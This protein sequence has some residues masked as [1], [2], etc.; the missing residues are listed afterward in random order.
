MSW[1]RSIGA[2]VFIAVMAL[3]GAVC[4]A[5]GFLHWQSSDPVKFICYLIAAAVASSLKVSLPGIEGTLSVNF[6]FTLLGI[7][8]LSLPETLVI[9]LAS[10]LA[11]F[12]WKP[13][14]RVKVVQLV[15]NLS[16]VTVS[17]AVAYGAYKLVVIYVLHAPG[18]LALL[19][20]AIT[21]FGCNTAATST[22]IG[23]TED[24]PIASV[25][26]ES[27]LWL[28]PY[29]MVG[30][31]VAG[32]VHFLNGHIG[33][34]S[35]LLILPPIYLMYRSY[36]LYL[37]KMETEKLHAEQVSNLHLRTIE[38]L[39]LAIEAK[40]ETTGEHLQ[41]VRVY[42]MALAKELGLSED[43]TE[44]LK[45][46]SVL[47]DIGK[48]AVPEHIIS[49]PG[50]LTP[51][52]FEKMKIHPIVGAE[53]LEQVHFPYPVVP[54]VRA[55]HE[56]WDGSGYPNGLAGEEIPIGAR[57][58]AAV[59]C[60]DALA[61]DRQYRKALPLNEAMAKVVADAG[62]AFD[63]KIVSILRR[64]YIELEKMATEEPLQAPPK[65][66]TDIK[67]QRGLAPAAGFAESSEPAIPTS[68][69]VADSSTRISAAQQQ[70]QGIVELCR[71]PGAHLSIEDILSLLAVRV[72]H[73]VPHDSMAV[74]MPK[75]GVL[76]AEFV[77]GDNF[78]LFSSLRIPEGEGLSG[79]VAQNHKP[80]LN[81][82]PSVEPGYLNDPKKYST[83]RAALAVPLE[84]TAGIAA[85]LALYRAGQDAFNADD[86]RVVEAIGKGLGTVIENAAKPKAS[87]IGAGST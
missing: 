12:Y 34:Q 69:Q 29:Y 85:V 36:R 28:F 61:S 56:K 84:G 1:G 49:K 46:A 54:I 33:W 68:A 17:S 6:L 82:N 87:A 52:E 2:R 11:Q 71:Q 38:A 44:A 64:R 67:V 76:A 83:L 63:P 18:P 72:K 45:A 75:N 3:A 21:H 59:D 86:L 26:G 8:E 27:H 23:L 41:R 65:L 22:I 19:V 25:W 7:L 35:S 50:K 58:L 30:A 16:Q 42:A 37:G 53:I 55:H 13:A 79:W 73:L 31:A 77:S 9:G 32:L 80:I 40:D 70:G 66:S 43:E 62:K 81:G 51:E 20:A 24:K 78:R 4:F 47:H 5:L 48:L 60:L 10:T 39:A 74:Y 15:F 14:R 57:I